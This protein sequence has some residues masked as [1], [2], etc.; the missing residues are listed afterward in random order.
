[1]YL[2]VTVVVFKKIYSAKEAFTRK[3]EV[4]IIC[5]ERPRMSVLVC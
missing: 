2:N 3:W 4:Q 5:Y 1:M